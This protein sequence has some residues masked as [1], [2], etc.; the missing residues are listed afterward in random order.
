MTSVA[1]SSEGE[2]AM[3]PAQGCPEV[4]LVP[5]VSFYKT[6]AAEVTPREASA[7]LTFAAQAARSAQG[8]QEPTLS[9]PQ[10]PAVE[11]SSRTGR[12]VPR[13]GTLPNQPVEGSSGIGSG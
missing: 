12:E 7:A 2:A 13:A 11:H 3:G 10:S 4:V 6:I 8:Y 1:K 9:N 5:P